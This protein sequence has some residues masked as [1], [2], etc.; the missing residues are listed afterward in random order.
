MTQQSMRDKASRWR[1]IC[2]EY[3]INIL[4]TPHYPKIPKRFTI[5]S[6]P[7]QSE[8]NAL[9]QGPVDLTVWLTCTQV[10]F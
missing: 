1:I 10:T 7:T 9:E 8:S 5:A 3:Y 2:F 4:L 6:P